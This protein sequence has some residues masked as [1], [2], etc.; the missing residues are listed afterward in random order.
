MVNQNKIVLIDIDDTIFNT[1]L[2]KESHFSTYEMYE[3]VHDA[4]E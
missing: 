3:E 4:L 1:A 2:L